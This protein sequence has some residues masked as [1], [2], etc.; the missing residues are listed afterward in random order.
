[1]TMG[2]AMKIISH[3][4]QETIRLGGCLARYLGP[5]DIVSL[6]GELGAGKTVFVKGIARGLGVAGRSVLSPTFVLLQ[7]HPRGRVP[8]YHFDLYRLRVPQDI[9]NLGYEEYFY[10]EGIT[11]IEWAERLKGLLPE[12]SL[13]VRLQVK[14]G[15]QRLI[16]FSARGRRY[17]KIL[18]KMHEGHRC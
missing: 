14:S 5:G 6:F 8:L 3:S 11:V 16:L 17:E 13:R 10:D 18:E 15:S 7:E 9:L 2:Q 12:E 1:M 4:P